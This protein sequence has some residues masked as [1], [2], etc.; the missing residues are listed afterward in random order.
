MTVSQ[1]RISSR[2]DPRLVK[3]ATIL[4]GLMLLLVPMANTIFTHYPPY[5]YVVGPLLL[6]PG[7]DQLYAQS[8]DRYTTVEKA[9]FFILALGLVLGAIAMGVLGYIFVIEAGYMII[10][11]LFTLVLIGIGLAALGSG[12]VGRTLWRAQTIPRWLAAFFAIALLCDVFVNAYITLLFGS[13]I[14]FYGL[15]WVCLCYYL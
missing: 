6:L 9:G 3:A 5:L 10:L 14:A 4:G 2:L 13:G 15:A 12:I 11:I 8:K 1:L 7:V